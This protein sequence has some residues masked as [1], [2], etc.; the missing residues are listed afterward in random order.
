MGNRHSEP[1]KDRRDHICGE[2]APLLE[3]LQEAEEQLAAGARPI[4][5]EEALEKWRATLAKIRAQC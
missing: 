3:K 5:L 2:D 4:P 1:P